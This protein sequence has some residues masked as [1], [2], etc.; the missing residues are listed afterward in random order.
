MK[1]MLALIQN[2]TLLFTDGLFITPTGAKASRLGYIGSVIDV[3]AGKIPKNLDGKMFAADNY[4]FGFEVASPQNKYSIG[5]SVIVN[6]YCYATSTNKNSSDYNTTI[7]G[8][9][10]TTNGVFL[11]PHQAQPSHQVSLKAKKQPIPLLNLYEQLYNKISRPFAFAGIVTFANLHAK[12][13]GKPPIDN[14][15]VFANKSLYYPFPEMTLQNTPAFIFGVI[16]NCHQTEY[17]EINKQ[18]EVAIYQ[19]PHPKNMPHVS[20]LTTH[21][22]TLTLKQPVTKITAITPQLA[23]KTLHVIPDNTTIISAKL[24]IFTVQGLDNYQ[25]EEK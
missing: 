14:L 20:T 4:R 3:I 23:D 24:N 18:L 2:L 9:N 16:T 7:S 22:H 5:E 15:N 8:P 13:I 1:W 6:N 21:V 10:F 17:E 19:I 25:Q 12:A 11:V